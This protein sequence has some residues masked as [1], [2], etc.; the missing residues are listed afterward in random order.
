MDPH[1]TTIH[2]RPCKHKA[3]WPHFAHPTWAPILSIILILLLISTLL[4]H[5]STHL[6]RRLT[7]RRN[8]IL[9]TTAARS[10]YTS[11]AYKAPPPP[12][13]TPQLQA[14]HQV[15]Q[16]LFP[17]STERLPLY[18]TR[19]PRGSLYQ[20]FQIPPPHAT[21]LKNS[22]SMVEFNGGDPLDVGVE[23]KKKSKTIHWH[24]VNRLNT[25]WGWMS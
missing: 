10:T 5:L 11:F 22:R 1:P 4:Y 21:R 2:H 8:R 25:A 13:P 17:A 14:D 9:T 19:T 23:R 12:S 24:G 7:H 16:L 18:N 20:T 15:Q 3:C 6:H